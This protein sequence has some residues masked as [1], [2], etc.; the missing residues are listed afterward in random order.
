M[1]VCENMAEHNEIGKIGEE[2]ATTFLVKLGFTLIER[3]YRITQGEIDIVM[4]KDGKFHFIEVKSLQSSDLERVEL[5][6]ITPEDNFTKKKQGRFLK[7]VKMYCFQRNV[8]QETP[9]Q[10]DLACVYIDTMSRSAR[11]KLIP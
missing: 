3:N 11:V 1:S 4:K 8:P 6:N 2:I 9:L 7:A 5:E 10:V